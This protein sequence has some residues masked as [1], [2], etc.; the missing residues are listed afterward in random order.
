MVSVVVFETQ[1]VFAIKGEGVSNSEVSSS[2]ICG[3]Q[4]CDESMT[5]EEKIRQ[6]LA[7]LAKKQEDERAFGQGRFQIGGVSAQARF[8]SCQSIDTETA[9]SAP[10]AGFRR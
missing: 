8:V 3:D 6:Y 7:Q 9:G 2:K 4:L 10:A 1:D 5:T